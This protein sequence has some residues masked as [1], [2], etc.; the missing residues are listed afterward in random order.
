[1]VMIRGPSSL[2]LP[3]AGMF[4]TLSKKF[5]MGYDFNKETDE[6]TW[7]ITPIP[8]GD[9]IRDMTGFN[10][11]ID[12]PV[13]AHLVNH[14]ISAAFDMFP[15]LKKSAEG[16]NN[17][18]FGVYVGWRS[19]HPFKAEL[20]PKTYHNTSYGIKNMSVT[21]PNLWANVASAADATL[22][23]SASVRCLFP[24]EFPSG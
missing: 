5:S 16:E 3:Q 18:K 24:S 15:Q 9:M 11:D 8:P 2:V 23:E 1:M 13:E 4:I 10:P 19:E 17:I 21:W 6:V 12:P 22:K 7:Y 20:Q 14:A